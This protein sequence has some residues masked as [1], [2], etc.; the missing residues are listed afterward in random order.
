[1][2]H[3]AVNLPRL[4]LWQ[5]SAPWL[6]PRLQGMGEAWGAGAVLWHVEP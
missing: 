5:T 2:E 6:V 3:L 1:M 4:C